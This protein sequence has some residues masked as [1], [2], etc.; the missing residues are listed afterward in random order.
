M[1][2]LIAIL[3]VS[4]LCGC[5]STVTYPDGK[6]MVFQKGFGMRNFKA[7]FTDGESRNSYDASGDSNISFPDINL[8][9]LPK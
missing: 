6:T 7:S 2:I 4:L 3:S 8:L 5:A 9:S 1:R